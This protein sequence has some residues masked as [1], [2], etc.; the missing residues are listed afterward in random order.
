MDRKVTELVHDGVQLW[1]LEDAAD[2]M[3]LQV[4]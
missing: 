1:V 4:L 2:Q 3:N